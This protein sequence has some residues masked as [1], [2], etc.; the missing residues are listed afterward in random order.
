M[1]YLLITLQF[2]SLMMALTISEIQGQ[3]DVS[4]HEG[5]YVSTSGYVTAVSPFSFFIQDG[6][7]LWNGIYVYDSGLINPSIGDEIEISGVVVEYYN[8]TE[9]DVTDGSHTV[10][11]S[12]NLIYNPSY[13]MEFNESYESVLVRISGICTQLPNE[14]GEWYLDNFM[15]D[16]KIY[17]DF[18]PVLGQE[19]TVTGPLDYSF[20]NFK[21]LPRDSNDIQEEIFIIGDLNQDDIINVADIIILITHILN[22]NYEPAG[23]LNNDQVIDILDIILLLNV[24]LVCNGDGTDLD[25]DGICDNIDD[26]VGEYDCQGTCNGNATEDCFGECGGD[27]EIDECGECGGDG[28]SEGDCDCDGNIFDDCYI[29]GG[30]SDPESCPP[31]PFEDIIAGYYDC[32]E[33]WSN[34]CPLGNNSCLIANPL[35]TIVDYFDVTPNNGPHIIYIEDE[36]GERLALII[37]PDNW[38]IANDP[39][40][41]MLLEAPYNRFSI[42]VFGNVFEYDGEKQ[43]N[44]CDSENLEIIEEFTTVDVTLSVDMNLN[45]N[46][47][48]NFN[49]PSIVLRSI[50]GEDI[51]WGGIENWF[52]MS[53]DNQDLIY[54]V[55]IP[56]SPNRT[57]GYALNSCYGSECQDQTL[58]HGYEFS[59][60]L[61]ECADGEF[62]NTRYFTTENTNVVLETICWESCY[63]C[64]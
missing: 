13:V 22:N 57:Y 2:L 45:E 34:S 11:S 54:E 48:I 14:H 17:S 56:L 31:I 25:N 44:I 18:M 19:Y 46:F 23:D 64:E 7:G 27:A 39:N 58:N 52:I 55:T 42:Q 51:E 12:E 6:Y 30:N 38:D 41:A 35:G 47:D 29:C 50:D 28:I 16:D 36:N 15:V 62:G 5:E 4:P 9:I 8:L 33:F 10:I 53:D 40:Y 3:A 43:I 59:D 63:A 60:N 20:N 61:Q 49:N 32:D 26:C 21:I 37:W 1:R 24:I